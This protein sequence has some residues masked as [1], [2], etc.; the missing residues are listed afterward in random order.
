VDPEAAGCLNE[1]VHC[2]EAEYSALL[3]ED[4]ER[5]DAV[6]AQKEQL[7]A[8]LASQPG[9]SP[10]GP[11]R[12]RALAPWRRALA[13]VRELNRRNAIALA[14]RAVGNRA[15]LRFLQT[16]LGRD[17]V[18]AADGSVAASQLRAPPQRSA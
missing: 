10:A 7:L 2:L 12:T 15:R 14:P 11:G 4:H 17:A 9:L 1:L 18:Y 5:L 13:H 6:L 8:R 3:A 16:A